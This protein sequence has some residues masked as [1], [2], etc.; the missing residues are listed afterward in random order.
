[1][2]IDKSGTRVREMFSAIAGRYD[3]LNHLLSANQDRRWRRRAVRLLTPRRGE[4]I[5]DLCCG[6]GDLAFECLRQQPRCSVA[7]ADFAVP[8]LQLANNK[9]ASNN[10][11]STIRNPQFLAG[12]ALRL[13]FPDAA[14][15]AAMV[16]FGARNF[17][18]T[19]AGLHEMRR[20]V[21]PG[22]RVLILEFMRP[23]SPLVQQ[24]FGLF[25][26]HVLPVIGRVV[27]QHGSA[28]NY[29][30]ASVDGF[31]TRRE[32]EKLLARVGFS[33][34]RSFDYS[35]GIATAFIGHK[36]PELMSKNTHQVNGVQRANP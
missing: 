1:M 12:D 25:F 13:P 34:V 14:F 20:V 3:L 2:E 35:G 7:G 32:F 29:L 6:T 21:K 5:L 11:Q 26:K 36:L 22:G 16:A 10:P 8:M 18:N 23:T 9:R 30:P 31:Y 4:K 17:E 27:S 19:E 28:Y 33:K 24:G 15:D